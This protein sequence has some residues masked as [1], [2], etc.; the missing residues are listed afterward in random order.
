MKQ[1]VW[2]WDLDGVI[3]A[4]PE[5]FS[6][7]SW[8]LKK[9]E[10]YNVIYILT[11]RFGSSLRKSE[12]IEDLIFFKI[13][14][15]FLIMAPNKFDDLKEEAKWKIDRVKEAEADI[16]VDNDFK[17]YQKNCGIDLDKSLPNVARIWI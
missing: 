12:T 8:H 10:N 11:G 2:C 6:W 9:N 7:F 4:Y 17:L 14:Y 16:W 15:D 13:K 3:T 5:V 1:L